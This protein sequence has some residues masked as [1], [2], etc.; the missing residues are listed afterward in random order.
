[1]FVAA[2][3]FHDVCARLLLSLEADP[4]KGVSILFEHGELCITSN[5]RPRTT[6][7]KINCAEGKHHPEITKVVET[8][9]CN[10]EAHFEAHEACAGG[11]G[12]GG[13]TFVFV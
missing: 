3:A 7:L 13:W 8:S 12:S 4:K 2:F 9:Q 10:Y 1:M 6:T 5:N 11:S